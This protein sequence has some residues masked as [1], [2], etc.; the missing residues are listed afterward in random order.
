MSHAGMGPSGLTRSREEREVRYNPLKRLIKSSREAVSL[1]PSTNSREAAKIGLGYLYVPP[2]SPR[3]Q[4]GG[5]TWGYPR[6]AVSRDANPGESVKK[7]G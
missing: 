6:I 3:P 4:R 5:S 7:K 1:S 2:Q